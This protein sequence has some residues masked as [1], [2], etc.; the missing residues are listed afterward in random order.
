MER[1]GVEYIQLFCVDNILVRVGDP[2]FTGYC[3][4]KKAEC[5]NKVV[6]KGFPTETVGITCLVDGHYQVVEYSEITQAS[7]EMRNADGSLTYSAANLCIHFFT[8]AFLQRICNRHERELI[9]HMAKKKIPFVDASGAVVKPDKPNGIKM[10]KFVFDVFR[11][12][13]NFVV[14]DCVR[15]EEFAPLKNAEGASDF[16]P[17]HCRNALFNL[18]HKFVA[19]AGGKLVDDKGCE[20]KPVVGMENNNNNDEKAELVCEISPLVSYAGEGL[21]E[22]VAGR[23]I[24]VP[25]IQIGQ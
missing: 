13:K 24:P 8:L 22:Y 19:N 20:L 12:A 1:R 6:P 11:F 25:A 23:S 21:E 9:H 3:I 18:H 17:A 16:T 2:V 15:E 4:S 10:E 5:A 7:A 14:W